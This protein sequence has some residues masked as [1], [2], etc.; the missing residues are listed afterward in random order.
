MEEVALRR[1]AEAEAEAAAR[2]GARVVFE[3]TGGYDRP[4]AA[5]L[6]AAGVAY[7]KVNPAQ[8]RQFARAIGV[9][10]KTDRVDAGVLAEMG[11]RLEL[12]PAMPVTPARRELQALA[13]RRRQLVGMRKQELTRSQ[14]TQD[15]LAGASIARAIAFFDCEIKELDDRIAAAV[16]AEPELAE[17]ARRLRTMPGVGPVIAAG[18]LAELPELGH[19]DRRAIAALA[20]LSPVA[21]DSGHR[22]GRRRRSCC[23]GGDEVG[24][25]PEHGVEHGQEL[26]GGGDQRLLDRQ[27]V[28]LHSGAEGPEARVAAR[29][30]QRRDVKQ[31]PR[32]RP[33]PPMARRARRHATAPA[34][35]HAPLP[36]VG[37][38]SRLANPPRGTGGL[39]LPPSRLAS[40]QWDRR[41]LKQPLH[42]APG[43]RLFGDIRTDGGPGEHLANTVAAG[44]TCTKCRFRFAT[45][46]S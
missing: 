42:Q 43:C 9:A 23:G 21:D 1:F 41:L 8:A 7:A 27:A 4:L 3:A 18:L 11:A 32:N 16:A 39:A 46:H 6:A 13:T 12:A 38:A 37:T 44:G 45:R 26:A 17:P 14:Q 31:R 19:L 33:P 22:R 34:A 10:A 30:V 24:S 20:G 40:P 36:R 25:G 5:A 15:P 28:G 29:G 2:E 35:A